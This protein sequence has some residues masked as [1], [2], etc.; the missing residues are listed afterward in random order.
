[1]SIFSRLE[2][3]VRA[4]DSRDVEEQCF[5]LSREFSVSRNWLVNNVTHYVYLNC[6]VEINMLGTI[7]KWSSGGHRT[8]SVA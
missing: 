8:L 1:L 2:F 6:S 7:S 5:Y 3:L 4:R